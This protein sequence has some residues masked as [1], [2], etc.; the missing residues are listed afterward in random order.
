MFLRFSV[1]VLLLL[2][3]L[4]SAFAASPN[5]ILI[6]IDTTR[7]DRMGF[8]GSDR[9][10]TPNLD[11][12]AQ[13]STIFAR[14]YAQEPL[15]T[16]SHAAILTG[17]YPQFNHVQDLG[18]A[19]DA[20]LPYLPDTLH[21]HGYRTAAFVGAYILDPK[22]AAK[23]F[24][25]GFDTYDAGFRKRKPGE[26][27]YQTV[28]RR[29]GT[30]VDHALAWLAHHPQGPYFL[31]LHFYDPHDP[32]DP[33][34]PYKSKYPSA[35]YDGE[36]AY[37]DAM[38]GKFI[39]ALKTRG[40]FNTSL[41]AVA[42][43]HGEAFGEHG[44][45]RHGIF[46]YDETIH[47]PLLIKL[48]GL[49]PVSTRVESRV[50]LADLA[51]TLLQVL[52]IPAPSSMQGQALLKSKPGA[53]PA[54][55]DLG[56]DRAV[57]SESDYAHRAFQWSM[58]RSW[59]QG[60]YLYVQAP[61]PELYDQSTD[62]QALKNLADSSHAVAE[63]LDSQLDKFRQKTTS[64]HGTQA[65]LDPQ[66][67][68]SLRALGYLASDSAPTDSDAKAAGIDPKDKIKIANDLHQAL[69]YTEE[70]NYTDAIPLLEKVCQQEP[71]A[72]TA[73]LELGRAYVH[74]KEY[75]KAIPVLRQAIEKVP[76][77][78]M[79]HYELGL[80]L[81]KTGQWE[82]AL[83]EFQAAVAATPTSAQMHFYLA[84]VQTRLKQIPEAMEE[85]QAA[86]KIDPDHFDSNLLY[87]RLLF[88]EGHPDKALPYL[89]RALQ[90][91]P[92]S[93]KGHVFLADVYQ[94]LGQP[95][96][97]ARERSLAAQ[98]RDLEEH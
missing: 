88:L 30:V 11:A 15:T 36:I 75:P 8:L 25:R 5:V 12:L 19:L 59:R 20:S 97:A 3:S 85:F 61:K 1:L 74:L 23:G 28:E 60:K 48:P 78:G 95:Q 40:L 64:E 31:W 84:A 53:A 45:M 29:A 22:A 63:T 86:L 67:T 54:P 37:S 13:Q 55:A 50:A 96:K 57:Y 51:P 91:D 93:R 26:D 81:V 65:K 7:A 46:L 72:S 71:N 79:T 90:V 56:P 24:D 62:P 80:A 6:T 14:A 73:F 94:Q 58:L 68:E 42:A 21:H 4:A 47:V 66:Q 32:Y 92:Q 18:T 89:Q 35:P 52:G 49:H 9:G 2:S 39:S 83:P 87:G 77:S 27:R 17:T 43:D 98:G 82:D 76:S 70:D 69:I 33:P 44:E 41:I 10:L 34:E 38:V 16:P